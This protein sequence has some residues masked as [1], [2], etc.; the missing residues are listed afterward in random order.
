LGELRRL[1][2]AGQ[3]N[4]KKATAYLGKWGKEGITIYRGFLHV[5]SVRSDEAHKRVDTIG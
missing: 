2:C 4:R 5:P 3:R 1:E